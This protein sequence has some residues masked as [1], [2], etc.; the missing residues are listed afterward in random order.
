MRINKSYYIDGLLYSATVN[1]RVNALIALKGLGF[2]PKGLTPF[3][4]IADF[5][6]Y[7]E[8]NYPVRKI[9]KDRF[10]VVEDDRYTIGVNVIRLKRVTYVR[11]IKMPYYN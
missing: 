4:S 9:G 5:V 6:E 7:F 3:K 8:D 1:G 2:S 10:T 11:L